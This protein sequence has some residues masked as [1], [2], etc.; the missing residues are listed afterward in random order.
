MRPPVRL[1]AVLCAVVYLAAAASGAQASVTSAAVT[2]PADPAEPYFDLRGGPPYP[3]LRVAGTATT[4]GTANNSVSLHCYRGARAHFAIDGGVF[5]V[6]AGRWSGSIALDKLPGIACRL[7]AI[8]VDDP[9]PTDLTKFTGPALR[10][11]ILELA[12]VG[13]RPLLGAATGA[14]SSPNAGAPFGWLLRDV[15]RTATWRL[16]DSDCAVTGGGLLDVSNFATTDSP[17]LCAASLSVAESGLLTTSTRTQL[18]VDGQNVLLPGQAATFN[19]DG[20]GFP[21][22][23]L[24]PSRDDA[25]FSATSS[26]ELVRCANP[27]YPPSEARCSA[28]VPTGVGIERRLRELGDVQV[29]IADAFV[30]T[31]GRAHTVDGAYQVSVVAVSDAPG[32]RFPGQSV[33]ATHVRGDP[34]PPLSAPFT[35]F[36]KSRNGLAAGDPRLAYGSLTF[37]DTPAA[38]RFADAGTLILQVKRSVPAN[39][40][41]APVEQTFATG[42]TAAQLAAPSAAAEDRLSPPAVTISSPA[43][44][45]HVGEPQIVVAGVAIDNRAVTELT[46]A[47]EKVVPG[48]D[49]SFSHRVTLL[50]GPNRLVAEARDAAGGVGRAAVTVTLDVTP[51]APPPGDTTSPLLS[52]LSLSPGRFR[53]AARGAS[54]VRRGPSAVSYRLS[55]PAQVRFT[56]QRAGEGRRVGGR[57]VEPKRAHRRAKGC[58][59]YR[60]LSGSFTHRGAAGRNAFRFSGRLHNS[61]LRPG[62][63][64]LRAVAADAAGNA[65]GPVHRPFR[66]LRR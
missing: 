43:D 42:R 8:P 56:V 49:G 7:R 48:A 13:V 23:A 59:R 5:A 41:S 11:S 58:T 16:G 36:V 55:E 1:R 33:F 52:A 17:W 6:S 32:W 38:A 57:C 64:R 37:G 30:S 53:A 22:L 40:S 2:V 29:D 47:G 35:V 65:S 28:Y 60:T 34:V 24:E 44:G 10:V 20:A 3:T 26:E 45:A 4:S 19:P 51:P 9:D 27:A 54:I 62:R 15:R 61:K 14:P 66:I 31:D 21:K 12:R 18:Q 63:Y 46:V 25:G 39:G 50:P